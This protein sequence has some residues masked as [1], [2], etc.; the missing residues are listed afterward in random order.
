MAF[1][2]YLAARLMVAEANELSARA[3]RQKR[4]NCE[5]EAISH[6]EFAGICFRGE[7]RESR[8]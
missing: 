8:N 2:V 4:A 5:C 3:T 6:A 7:A 1:K